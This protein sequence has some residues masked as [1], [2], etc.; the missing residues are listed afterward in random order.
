MAL[1]NWS[2]PIVE[3]VFLDMYE[4]QKGEVHHKTLLRTLDK[5]QQIHHILR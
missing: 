4:P 3:D 5:M 2:N 1:Q